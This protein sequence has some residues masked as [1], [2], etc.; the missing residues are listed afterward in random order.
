ML[1]LASPIG[2][3][4]NWVLLCYQ[5]SLLLSYFQ[6]PI[7]TIELNLQKKKKKKKKKKQKKIKK[8]KKKQKKKKKNPKLKEI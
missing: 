2:Q 1:E 5:K 4:K 7:T 3:S 8:K 6:S